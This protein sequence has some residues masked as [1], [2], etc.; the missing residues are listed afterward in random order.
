[1]RDLAH[2][3]WRESYTGKIFKILKIFKL[4]T[5]FSQIF[6]VTSDVAPNKRAQDWSLSFLLSYYMHI[7]I[8]D[9]IGAS[10]STKIKM[11]K[12]LNLAGQNLQISNFKRNFLKF[13]V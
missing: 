7:Q 9:F 11:P 3:G 6:R 8:D 12:K 10:A 2:H 5:R 1:V 4:L 13:F